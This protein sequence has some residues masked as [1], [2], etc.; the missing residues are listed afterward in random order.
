[1]T[2]KCYKLGVEKTL[3]VC[4]ATAS[5]SNN[6]SAG[7]YYNFSSLTGNAINHVSISGSTLTLA[8][9]RYFVEGH[10]YSDNRSSNLSFDFQWEQEI[11]SSWTLIG[12][13]GTLDTNDNTLGFRRSAAYFKIDLTSSADF[14]LKVTAN[15][16]TGSS[17]N[18]GYIQVWRE[19]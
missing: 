6:V 9:G 4:L 1:M 19:S 8:A 14:K 10:P 17:T 2:Y 16:D 3:E 12:T 18:H 15:N 11:D 7:T 13:V 5:T